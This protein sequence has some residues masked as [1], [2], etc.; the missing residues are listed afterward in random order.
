[1]DTNTDALPQTAVGPITAQTSEAI[2]PRGPRTLYY[3]IGKPSIFHASSGE[4]ISSTHSLTPFALPSHLAKQEKP[5]ATLREIWTSDQ[6]AEPA[7]PATTNLTAFCTE[8]E[9][10]FKRRHPDWDIHR[11]KSRSSLKTLHLIDEK[12]TRLP[13]PP[14]TVLVISE[15]K[16]LMERMK[17]FR[18]SSGRG[19]S[20][21]AIKVLIPRGDEEGV[22]DYTFRRDKA[23]DVAES[24]KVGLRFSDSVAPLVAQYNRLGDRNRRGP[25]YRVQAAPA[26][27]MS[28]LC[29]EDPW[30]DNFVLKYGC[31]EDPDDSYLLE[32]QDPFT[33]Y[34]TDASVRRLSSSLFDTDSVV[35]DRSTDWASR[36]RGSRWSI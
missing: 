10:S 11:L 18:T 6:T 25:P 7:A 19:S 14:C 8:L 35:N 34:G 32:E 23:R 31:P 2:A 12:S 17:T 28:D 3:H 21:S 9:N 22:S 16:T 1:M 20:S 5:E 4:G 29:L 13:S 27:V 26:T 30:A 15:E 33:H 36:A 24:L